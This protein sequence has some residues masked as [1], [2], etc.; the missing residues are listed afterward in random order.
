MRTAP[1]SADIDA[2]ALDLA[3]QVAALHADQ[4]ALISDYKTHVAKQRLFNDMNEG[5]VRVLIGSVA[6]MGTGVNAQKRLRAIHN[7]DAMWYPADDT[8]RNGR[9]IRQGNMNP[10]VEITEVDIRLDPGNAIEVLRGH[11]LL[12][13]ATDSM[14]ASSAIS[15]ASMLGVLSSQKMLLAIHCFSVCA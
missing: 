11:D 4:V 15:A 8:Q 1:V 9:A 13:D 3:V 5:K 7:M 2:Q 6:K 14:S 12:V 10:E